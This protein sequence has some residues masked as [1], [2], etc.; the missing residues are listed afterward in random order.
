M[1]EDLR[2]LPTSTIAGGI[3]PSQRPSPSRAL[4]SAALA[5]EFIC[6]G[7]GMLVAVSGGHLLVG[8]AG[9]LGEFR[10]TVG[11]GLLALWVGPLSFWLFGCNVHQVMR[12]TLVIGDFMRERPITY[13]VIAFAC[14]VAGYATLGGMR[15]SVLRIERRIA[16]Q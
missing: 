13:S 15:V 4:Y 9:S 7:L 12:D 16:E 10:R 14:M 11:A 5:G 6:A 3:G 8:D 2:D 1:I